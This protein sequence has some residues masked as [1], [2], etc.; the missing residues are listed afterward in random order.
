MEVSRNEGVLI[1]LGVCRSIWNLVILV[2]E[3]SVVF[4]LKVDGLCFAFFATINYQ[5]NIIRGINQPQDT[6][7][8]R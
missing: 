2:K 1:L 5:F 3:S 7:T 8:L 6:T 4:R